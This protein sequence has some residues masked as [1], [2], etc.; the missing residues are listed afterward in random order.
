MP[1]TAQPTLIQ[2]IV[3]LHDNIGGIMPA[4]FW[5]GEVGQG[6]DY[7]HAILHDEG[8]IPWPDEGAYDFETGLPTGTRAMFR[9]EYIAENDLAQA[10]AL[11]KLAMTTFRPQSL[12]LTFCDV[13]KIF[14]F[15][16]PPGWVTAATGTRSKA[17]KPT[18][19]SVVH[20]AVQFT[21]DY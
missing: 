1:V 7:P 16:R 9:L 6:E 8:E 2:A 5:L 21:T 18:F 17:D 19:S 10:L 13:S 15:R 3:D 20:Y 12:L 4:K 14:L 11:A